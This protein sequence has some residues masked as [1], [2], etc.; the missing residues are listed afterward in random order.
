MRIGGLIPFTLI[1]YPGK[2]AA[3]MFTQ[4]CNFRCPFC[5]N[6]E[7]LPIDVSAG[8]LMPE[9][10]FFSFLEQKR[11]KLE[12]LVVSGGE[13]TLQPDL[14][15]FFARVKSLGF[16]TKLDTNGSR[17]DVLKKL[18]AERVVDFVAMDIKA[19]PAKYHQLAGVRA[20]L[21]KVCESIILIAH[22]GLEH[23]FRT[24]VVP[25]LLSEAD[26][27]AIEAMVPAGS[28]YVRQRFRPEKT[29]ANWQKMG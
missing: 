18:F 27:K 16:L 13:P 4:G 15:P 14:L 22:S 6:A 26:V 20:P 2:I 23:Q 10:E 24:T 19:P 7:L 29:L 5:H 12:G 21:G 8:A 9:D 25:S 1:D 11:G 17:P 28:P 3:T